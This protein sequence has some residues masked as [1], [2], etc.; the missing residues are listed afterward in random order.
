MFL[1]VMI[2]VT[3]EM[4]LNLQLLVVISDYNNGDDI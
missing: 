2:V 3:W 4:I 1:E